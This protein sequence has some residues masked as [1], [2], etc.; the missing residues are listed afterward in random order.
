MN[1]AY[2]YGS[3]PALEKL[4]LSKVQNALKEAIAHAAGVSVLR[5]ANFFFKQIQENVVAFFVI[6]EASGVA[7]AN[8][9]GRMNESSAVEAR[10]LLN[11]T[12]MDRD[13]SFFVIGS[14]L[15]KTVRCTFY[16]L[17]FRKTNL[18]SL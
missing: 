11:S 14:D 17:P 1:M 18:F 3:L 7:P 4:G 13:V 8:T 15:S 9:K 5:V 6:G 16:C 10:E 2:A 12:L